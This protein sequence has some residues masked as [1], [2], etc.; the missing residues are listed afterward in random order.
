[1]HDYD[2]RLEFMSL[3]LASIKREKLEKFSKWGQLM[4]KK[5]SHNK[6]FLLNKSMGREKKEKK[7]F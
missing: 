7:D 5:H 1:M 6:I 3:A 2:R 4:P